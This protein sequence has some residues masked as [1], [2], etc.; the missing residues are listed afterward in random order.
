MKRETIILILG[1]GL[2]ASC[3]SSR[4]VQ[5]S[6][7][8]VDSSV[9]QEN[10]MLKEAV[11]EMSHTI[12]KLTMDSSSQVVIFESNTPQMP[13]VKMDSSIKTFQWTER[14][15]DSLMN[16]R[17]KP[18]TTIKFRPD[19]SIESIETDQNIKSITAKANRTESE[20]DSLAEVNSTLIDSLAYYKAQKAVKIETVDKKVSKSWW[21]L[22]LIIGAV[23]GFAVRHNLPW[24]KRRMFG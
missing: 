10:R 5:R 1:V 23:G 8:T 13:N 7:A 6:T 14:S 15:A 18:K 24:I 20:R 16:L 11:Q 17:A 12:E 3:S 21:W 19:K 9:I 4:S 22:W 2:L